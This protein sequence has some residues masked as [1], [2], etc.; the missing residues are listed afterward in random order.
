MNLVWGVTWLTSAVVFGSI[1]IMLLGATIVMQ[2]RPMR[3]R[4]AVAGLMLS[5][6]AGYLTPIQLLVG[7]DVPL[8]LLLSALFVGLPIFF[9]S[10]CFALRFRV[11]ISPDIAF[12]WNLLGA[13]AGGLLEFSSMAIGFKALSLLAMVLYLAAFVR[14]ARSAKSSVIAEFPEHAQ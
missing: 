6:L 4:I 8:K 11:R 12:G 9:A 7:Q 2:L 3:W 14:P 5:L 10:V 1:L 13:V